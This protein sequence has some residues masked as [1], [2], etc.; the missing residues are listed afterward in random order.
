MRLTGLKSGMLSL[1]YLVDDRWPEVEEEI[2]E[3]KE[4]VVI[5]EGI[6]VSDP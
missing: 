4:G 6:F 3:E 1:K 2:E 5:E